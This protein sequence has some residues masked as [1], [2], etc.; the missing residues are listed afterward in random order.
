MVDL[1]S[2]HENHLLLSAEK[3]LRLIDEYAGLRGKVDGFGSLLKEEQAI[4]REIEQ[5]EN[6]ERE[7]KKQEDFFRFQFEE[8]SKAN[9]VAAEEATAGSV[10][11]KEDR[12]SPFNRG[13]SHSFLC[14]SVP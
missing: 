14:S 4:Q 10:I 8:L 1:H 5:L 9:L 2:Q 7:A 6:D 3:Q 12:I 11:A 13:S